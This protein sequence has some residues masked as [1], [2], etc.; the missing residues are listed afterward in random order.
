MC[1]CV[2]DSTLFKGPEH[3]IACSDGVFARGRCSAGVFLGPDTVR[4]DDEDHTL[5]NHTFML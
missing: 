3:G 1:V 5:D 2:L 4:D